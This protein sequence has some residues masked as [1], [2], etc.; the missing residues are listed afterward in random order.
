LVGRWLCRDPR[1]GVGCPLVLALQLVQY[2]LAL[3]VG[4]DPVEQTG[5]GRPGG[6]RVVPQLV[7]QLG[8]AIFPTFHEHDADRGEVADD[9]RCSAALAGTRRRRGARAGLAVPGQ[10]LAQRVGQ[11]GVVPERLCESVLLSRTQLL[12]HRYSLPRQY[13]P[14]ILVR[15]L[16]VPPCWQVL[17][18]A[19]R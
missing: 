11:L 18:R 7:C 15:G 9:V 19:E 2:L 13:S 1:G 5:D 8:D 4:D 3:G 16:H 17:G 14:A 10:P 12:P 6:I